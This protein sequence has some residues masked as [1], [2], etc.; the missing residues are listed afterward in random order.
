MGAQVL[1]SSVLVREKGER[2]LIVQD[3]GKSEAAPVRIL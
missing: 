2:I 1:N 3:L